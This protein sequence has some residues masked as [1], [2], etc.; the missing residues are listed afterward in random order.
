MRTLNRKPKKPREAQDPV[1]T[2]QKYDELQA[3]LNAL[4]KKRPKAA[5]EVSRLA[6]MGDFSENV[7]YQLAK[8]RLRGI[9]YGILKLEDKLRYAEI[10]PDDGQTDVVT[11]GSTVT[12]DMDGSHKTYTIL[13]S[14]ETD[15]TRGIISHTS[16]LGS[17]LLGKKLDDS[18]TFGPADK[19]IK[20]IEI[21]K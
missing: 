5:A 7:E 21:K 16:P 1:M 13:G 20:I 4:H 19:T 10:I 18:T 9:N 12:I 6:E 11:I 17:T 14:T 3:E 8:R 2:Q 15:P